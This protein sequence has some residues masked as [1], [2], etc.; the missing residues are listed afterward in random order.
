[1]SLKPKS[2][3]S[4]ERTGMEMGRLRALR[5]KRDGIRQTPEQLWRPHGSSDAYY[6]A[7]Q[8]GYAAEMSATHPS[9]DV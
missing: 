2:Q 3:Q 4:E 5:D 8:R 1:M 7:V 6:A 9:L